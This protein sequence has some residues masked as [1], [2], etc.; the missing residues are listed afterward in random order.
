MLAM[1]Q[2]GLRLFSDDLPPQMVMPT[3]ARQ[4]PATAGEAEHVGSIVRSHLD[5]DVLVRTAKLSVFIIQR[6]GL[7]LVVDVQIL[8]ILPGAVPGRHVFLMMMPFLQ[9]LVTSSGFQP[10][11]SCRRFIHPRRFVTTTAFNHA[12]ARLATVLDPVQ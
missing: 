11:L 3:V 1:F 10:R 5:F 8:K 12:H 7:V 2:Q 9:M 6:A 4:M